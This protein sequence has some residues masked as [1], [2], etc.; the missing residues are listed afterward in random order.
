M[1]KPLK[2]LGLSK[3]HIAGIRMR[4]INVF[5][6]KNKDYSIEKLMNACEV[7]EDDI[8]L[9]KSGYFEQIKT[10]TSILNWLI[11]NEEQFKKYFIENEILQDYQELNTV[12]LLVIM[13]GG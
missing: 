11:S 4:L 1:Y 6:D 5:L 2:E 7:S 9:I 10:F 8:I 3:T 12:E 13:N